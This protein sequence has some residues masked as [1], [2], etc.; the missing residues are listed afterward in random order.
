VFGLQQLSD[1]WLTV[2]FA[3]W[4]L[5]E[6]SG[7]GPGGE[8]ITVGFEL[9]QAVSYAFLHSGLAHIAM[10]MLGL[11]SLGGVVEQVLGARNFII[12]Y[13]VCVV[14]AALAQLLVI[15]FFTGGFY[16]TVGASGGVFGVMMAFALMFPRE[17]LMVFPIPLPLPAWLFVT[18]YTAA[19]LYFGVT[20]TAAGIAHFAHLG[21]LVGGFVLL[22]YWRGR[23]PFKPARRLQ[24]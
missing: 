11:Y 16:P 7:A 12:Y 17:K 15:E 9:W 24:R 4:P 8:T 20:G 22:Q 3:L 2:Y 14:T 21:G 23:L 18:L 6:V 19:E 5:G 13:L 10:N 1:G